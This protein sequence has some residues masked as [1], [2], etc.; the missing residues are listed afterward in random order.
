MNKQGFSPQGFGG[1][2][3]PREPRDPWQP[4]PGNAPKGRGRGGSPLRLILRISQRR[5]LKNSGMWFPTQTD[6]PWWKTCWSA[7]RPSRRVLSHVETVPPRAAHLGCRPQ[8]GISK[9]TGGRKSC[10]PSQGAA[11]PLSRKRAPE[12]PNFLTP[13]LGCLRA[14]TAADPTHR[15]AKQRRAFQKGLF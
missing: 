12:I 14:A 11:G 3:R 10:L 5:P 1:E 4:L 7:A 13:L 2:G 9:R 15:G 8:K 6:P